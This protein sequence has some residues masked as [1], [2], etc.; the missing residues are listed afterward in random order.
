MSASSDDAKHKAALAALA[1]LPP[2]GVIGIGTG[3][4]SRRFIAAL[5][6]LVA[7]GRR[8]TC[9]PTSQASRIQATELGIP[10]LPDEGPWDIAVTVD[11]ADE[12]DDALDLIKG[13]GGAHTREKIV[14][15]SSRRNVIIVDASKLSRRLGERWPLPVEVLPFA[16]L[17]TRDRLARHGKPVLRLR[18]GAPVRTDSG[19]LIYDLAC[20]P[21]GDPRALDGALHAIPGVVETGLFVGRA[22]VVLVA[23]DSG[24]ERRVPGRTRT[25]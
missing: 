4:T 25:V 7:R 3:S 8:Y 11:G 2:D 18:D 14:N 10:L 12:V 6:E 16:H 15:F 13:G 1:E 17:A 9:V 23:G 5:G 20:G 22:D 21:I 24:V 19:N